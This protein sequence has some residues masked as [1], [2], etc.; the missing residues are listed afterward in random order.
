MTY[1]LC[2]FE[3]E[4]RTLIDS[5]RLKK[6]QTEPYTLFANEGYILIISGMGQENGKESSRYLLSN[7]PPRK[8]DIFINLGVCAAKEA[9]TIGELLQV[10]TL[11]NERSSYPL[12][13]RD[14]SIKTVSCFSATIPLDKASS[15]DIAEM[16]ALSVYEV[17]Q[18]SFRKEKISFLKIVSDNFRPFIPKKQFIIGLVHKNIKTIQAHIK[19]LQG[20]DHVR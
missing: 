19:K 14:S 16:E 3:A 17:I 2:A 13:I 4:A 15:S 7:F 9:Y 5:Y 11:Q 12:D 8:D 20:E 1:I 10:E 6:E 18:G